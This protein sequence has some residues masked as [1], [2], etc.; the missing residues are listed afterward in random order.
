M[1]LCNR[2][3][4]KHAHLQLSKEKMGLNN[5]NI[6][7][8][9]LQYKCLIIFTYLST[10]F[11]IKQHDI[12]ALTRTSYL[13]FHVMISFLSGANTGGGSSSLNNSID[14]SSSIVLSCFR[15][16]A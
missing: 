10:L 9:S 1:N 5:S 11:I 7:G 14:I 4:S 15:L 8:S 16:T 6:L 2:C 13:T 12:Q 3:Q